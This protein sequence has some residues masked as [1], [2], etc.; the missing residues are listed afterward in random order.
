M[1]SELA[2]KFELSL[3]LPSQ[4]LGIESKN[5]KW[6]YARTK[7]PVLKPKHEILNFYPLHQY[8]KSKLLIVVYRYKI[9][10]IIIIES[11]TLKL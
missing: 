5:R 1:I 4:N 9:K 8:I 6:Q 11:K 10:K 7:V 2:F 3:R